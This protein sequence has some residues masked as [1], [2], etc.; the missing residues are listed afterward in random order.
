[1]KERKKEG[2][3]DKQNIERWE[4]RREG[5]KADTDEQTKIIYG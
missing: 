5:E 4:E 1:M 3:K 2:D